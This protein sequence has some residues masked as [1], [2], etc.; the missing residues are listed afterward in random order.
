MEQLT[1]FADERLITSCVHCGGLTETRDHCPSRVFLDEPYPE[2]LPVVPACSACNG[3][4]SI[5]EEYLACLV[6]CARTGSTD[7][8]ERLK[9][10]QILNHS[11]ALAAR[12]MQARS[13]TGEGVVTF[14]VEDE[15]VKRIVMKLARGHAAFELSELAH[16]EPSH[17][18]FTPLH[19]LSAAA[20]NHFETP[21]SSEV[22]PEVGSRAMQRMALEWGSSPHPSWIVLQPGQ[23]RYL[24]VAEI[25]VMIRVVI[26]EY[27]ACEVI[28]Q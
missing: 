28:W 16:K 2:H 25:A 1:P 17:I 20:R 8:V 12:L 22:W 26:G 13:L 27:L 14:A 9:V 10:R 7:A 21:P 3:G 5:D 6:E 11:P 24:A 19:L 4:F 23:Y 18:M 15:R